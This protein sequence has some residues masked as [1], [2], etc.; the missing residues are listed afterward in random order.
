MKAVQNFYKS[1]ITQDWSIGTGIFYVSVKPTVPE[2]WL[3]VSPNNASLRE[4]IYYNGTGTDGNG[5]Y[6]TV[7]QRGVG[8]TD[9]QTHTIGEPIRMNIDEN[10]WDY[11]T[12]SIEAIVAAGTPD[13]DTATA[14]KVEIATDAEVIAGTETGGTDAMLVVTPK[15]LGDNFK[16]IAYNKITAP[17]VR[18]YT[19][20]ATWTKPAGLR[21]IEVEVQG[22]GGNGA[23]GNYNSDVNG[24]SGGSGGYARK[25]I[26]ASDLGATETIVVGGINGTSSFGSIIS[27]T[28]GGNGASSGTGGTAGTA[29][30]GDL[31]INGVAGSNGLVNNGSSQYSEYRAPNGA[32]SFLGIG[33]LADAVNGG[34][35]HASGYGAGGSGASDEGSVT[36]GAGSPGI[37][38]VKEFYI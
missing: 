32:N 35:G 3:V 14:G 37:V 21:Y 31:N 24:G 4:V 34:A 23:K 11:L 15:T 29:T 38:I 20:N 5:D 26:S 19:S 30:G 22:G 16:T 7:T 27:C 18:V 33:G 28:G 12:D 6:I 9:E 8:T 1:T 36:A 10:Y 17:I 13:A 2:G 25:S